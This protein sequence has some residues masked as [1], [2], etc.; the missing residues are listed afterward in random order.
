ML[1]SRHKSLFGLADA[2]MVLTC[3]LWGLNTVISK[4]AIGNFP[5]TFRVFIY[6][7]LRI[8]I[9]TV[10]IIMAVKYTGGSIRVKKKHIP[11][12]A[13]LAFF[14]M[15]MFMLAFILGVSLTSSTNT[16]VIASTI[17]L[18]ILIVSFISG[19]ERPTLRTI[20]GIAVGFC[21]MLTLTL[22]TGGISLNAG[23]LI[24]LGSCICWAIHTVYGKKLLN[25]Y[26]PMVVIVWVYLFT[27]LYH[28]PL[29]IYQIPGQ[30]WA[31]ITALNWFYLAVSAIGSAFIANCLYYYSIN[32]IGPSKAGVYTNLTPVFTLL[33]AVLIRGE[34]ITSQHIAG[35]LL[36][37]TGIAVSKSGWE[38]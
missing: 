23:D 21:G 20:S 2:A 11:Y 9:G 25:H 26:S 7:G 38:K 27:S 29:A 24:L 28:I 4:N 30:A 33:L 12:I 16:G 8:P 10:F 17:P 36:I 5:E 34:T 19:I 1:N 35:L 22:K 18:F 6:N 32:K 3:F 13:V 15:F 14:G 37:M 31:S